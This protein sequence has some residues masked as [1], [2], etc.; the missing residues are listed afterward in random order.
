MGEKR[1]RAKR[2]RL[3]A[4][5]FI[6]LLILVGVSAAA[7]PAKPKPLTFRWTSIAGFLLDDGETTLAFDVTFTRPTVLHWAGL[8]K[9]YPDFPVIDENV[10]ALGLKKVDAIFV[11]HEHVDHS[12][13]AA[14]LGAR[15]G[16]T[17]YGGPS[18]ERI[19]KASRGK[20]GWPALK[21]RGVADRET[22]TVGKFKIKFFRRTHAAIFPKIGFHFLAGEVPSDFD[23]GFYQ[24]HEG[25]VWCWT[26]E[27]PAGR[28]LVDQGSHFFEGLRSD[29]RGG[30]YM[31]LGVSNK[32]S[33][34]DFTTKYVAGFR[35]PLVLPLHFDFFFAAPNREETRM[36]PGIEYE[37]LVSESAK[38]SPGTR[39]R[40]PKF[41]EPI[42]VQ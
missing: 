7:E 28:I 12:V 21:F 24:Y 22:V 14:A 39:W 40:L 26:I 31:F 5:P 29:L 15:F 6:L 42:P 30:E 37:R 2:S 20:F 8:E 34:E 10:N 9:L 36:L 1:E 25:D 35:P 18:L 32:E 3:G 33:V 41:G 17:V 38:V 13:D 19:V 11:S 16:A 27:H 23:F 4:F